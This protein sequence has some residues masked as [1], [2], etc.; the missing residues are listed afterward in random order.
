M[1]NKFVITWISGVVS[2]KHAND[3]QKKKGDVMENQ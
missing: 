1:F 2:L 3:Y